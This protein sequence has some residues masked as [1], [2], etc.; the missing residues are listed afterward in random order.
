[1]RNRSSRRRVPTGV[2]LAVGMVISATAM[3]QASTA[4]FTATTANPG[5]S[6]ATGNVVLTADNTATAVFTSTAMKPTDVVVK[7]I[8]VSYTGSVVNTTA[9]KFY[10]TSTTDPAANGNTLGTYFTVKIEEGTGTANDPTCAGAFTSSTIIFDGT[11]NQGSGGAAKP[12]GTMADLTQTHGT[13][14]TNGFSCGWTPTPS[15]TSK[16]YKF[17]VT[18]SGT[19][20]DATDNNLQSKTLT[21]T[22]NWEVHST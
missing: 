3:W 6:W 10:T 20:T 12:V 22:F 19:G 21:T 16:S 5:D 8:N 17:T 4:A 2:V 9:V 7:C 15:S 13:S 1:M 18:F 11:H 14:Y